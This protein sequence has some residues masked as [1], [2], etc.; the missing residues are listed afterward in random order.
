DVEEA[1]VSR[2]VAEDADDLSCVIDTPGRCKA[3]AK[4]VDGGEAAVSVAEK[5]VVERW[6]AVGKC[7]DDLSSVVDAKRLCTESPGHVDLGEAAVSVAEEAV[8]CQ[9]GAKRADELPRVVDATGRRITRNA[10]EV[11][12]GKGVGSV[13]EAVD[14][15]PICKYADDLR[16]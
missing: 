3:C 6:C 9:A 7:P 1:V 11:D 13:Q 12:G 10:G 8:P 14:A 15:R 5:A 16:R 4:N 2:A